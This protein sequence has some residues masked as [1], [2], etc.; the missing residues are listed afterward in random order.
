M[1]SA[2]RV[3]NSSRVWP[4]PRSLTY[5]L[6]STAKISRTLTMPSK[7]RFASTTNTAREAGSC[8]TLA[9][10]SSTDASG[11]TKS[12][13]LLMVRKQSRTFIIVLPRCAERLSFSVSILVSA[14]K[15]AQERRC[16]DNGQHAHQR[17]RRKSSFVKNACAGPDPRDN[18]SHFPAR[19]HPYAN[20]QC[21]PAVQTTGKG[22]STGSN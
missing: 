1:R 8:V 16:Q 10:T 14:S 22:C 21:L 13:P 9:I 6:P 7:R 5:W 18:E 4:K 15:P 12:T 3:A 19:H 2:A 20:Y 17:R 11:D